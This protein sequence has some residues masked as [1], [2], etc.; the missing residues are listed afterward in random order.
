MHLPA[1]CDIGRGVVVIKRICQDILSG[2]LLLLS[3]IIIYLLQFLIF[4]SLKNTLFNFLQDMAFVPV[5]ILFITMILSRIL[6]LREKREKLVTINMVESTFF[7]EVGTRLILLLLKFNL[8]IE[9]LQ[10]KLTLKIDWTDMQFQSTVND[11]RIFCYEINSKAG[12]LNELKRFLLDKRHFLLGLLENPNLLED[13]KFTDL[14]L[15]VFHITDELDSRNELSDLPDTDFNHLSVDIKRVY[16]LLIY[17]WL[18]Y[19]KYLKMNY[20]FLYSL[21]IRKNPFDPDASVIVRKFN[22]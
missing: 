21:A 8:N 15:A 14:L 22:Y 3:S 4:K 1:Y 7:S 19:L 11:V 16:I 17:E 5:N 13:N 2:A 20:P 10:R 9:E 12:D 6:N 18:Y